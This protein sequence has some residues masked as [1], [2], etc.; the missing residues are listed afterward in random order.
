DVLEIDDDVEVG[1]KRKLGP[2]LKSK[3]WEDFD[4]I[5]DG[6]VLVEK[7][8]FNQDVARK[9]LALMICVNEYLLS[10][11]DHAGFRKFCAAMQ[12]LFKV[13]S[14]NTIRKD[15]LDMYE[16]QKQSMVNQF[17]Q[18]EFRI[19]VTTDMLMYVPHPH[20]TEVISDVLNDVLMDWGIDKKVSTIT[21]DNCSTNDNVVKEMQD[22]MPLSS[23]MLRGKLLH[24]CCACHIINLMVKDGLGIKDALGVKVMEE[25][26]GRIRET[27]G[28]GHP[29]QKGMR[30]EDWKFARHVCDRLKLFFDVTELLSGTSYV[31]ANLFSPR[32]V[33]NHRT[34]VSSHEREVIEILD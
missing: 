8:V 14:R 12:P 22:K 34:D 4:K 16:V 33:P 1:E 3:V 27:I 28:F 6:S 26:I 31:I 29:H 32:Y 15:I 23:L 13:V 21:L 24:M 7:Y 2:K 30:V 17:Q 19:A 10:M 25:A 20:T 11:V 5:K 9:E 18:E